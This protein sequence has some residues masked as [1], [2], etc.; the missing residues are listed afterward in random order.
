M[1]NYIISVTDQEIQDQPIVKA[2]EDKLRLGLSQ[3]ARVVAICLHPELGCNVE[4]LS[5][6]ETWQQRF[7]KVK[8]QFYIIPGNINQLECLEV[9]HPDQ[10]LKYVASLIDLEVAIESI[11]TQQP[12]PEVPAPAET[13][14]P[15]PK[16]EKAEETTGDKIDIKEG[17]SPVPEIEMDVGSRVE[18]SGEYICLGCKR[19]RMWL[20]GDVSEECDNPECQNSDAGWKLTYELF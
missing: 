13:T 4:L 16:F 12:V 15:A 18:T 8:K 20:K 6:L 3:T 7:I 14:A 10:G 9:S 1:N 11:E 17:P 5:W 2:F 19:S